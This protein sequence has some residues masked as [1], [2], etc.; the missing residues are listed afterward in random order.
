[1]SSI[2]HNN[3]INELKIEQ[4]SLGASVDNLWNQEDSNYCL[5]LATRIPFF[6][7]LLSFHRISHD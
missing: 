7:H 1:M 2:V 6:H 5:N 4:K 3:I